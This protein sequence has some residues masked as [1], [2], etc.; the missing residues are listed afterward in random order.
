MR[1]IIFKDNNG[2]PTKS[3]LIRD[4]GVVEETTLDENGNQVKRIIEPTVVEETEAE[5][6]EVE[7]IEESTIPMA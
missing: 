7:Q 1:Y 4:D 3:L 6:I 5:P 2:N